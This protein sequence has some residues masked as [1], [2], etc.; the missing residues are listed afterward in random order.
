MEIHVIYFS[1]VLLKLILVHHTEAI[2]IYTTHS[3]IHLDD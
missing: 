2:E 3:N 1:N